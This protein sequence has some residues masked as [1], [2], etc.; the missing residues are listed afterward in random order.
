MSDATDSETTPPP[1]E[2]TRP[3]APA[4]PRTRDKQGLDSPHDRRELFLLAHDIPWRAE[5]SVAPRQADMMRH[6]FLTRLP[7]LD[8]L[9]YHNPA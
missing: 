2:R 9:T 8:L 6:K 3:P 4:P 1:A 5:L 7:R